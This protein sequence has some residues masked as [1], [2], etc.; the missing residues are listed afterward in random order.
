MTGKE[1]VVGLGFVASEGRNGVDDKEGCRN[2]GP[3]LA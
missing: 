1:R 3:F 2:S